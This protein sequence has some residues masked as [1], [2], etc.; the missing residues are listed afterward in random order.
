MSLGY[1]IESDSDK[2][3]L[4]NIKTV[5]KDK[6]NLRQ[7]TVQ[8]LSLNIYIKMSLYRGKSCT[9]INPQIH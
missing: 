5:S 7:K 2:R 9:E 8:D 1:D 4:K 3:K 6:A